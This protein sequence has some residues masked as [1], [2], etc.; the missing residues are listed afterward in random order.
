MY[1]LKIQY[2]VNREAKKYHHYDQVKLIKMN[3]LQAKKYCH[4]LKVE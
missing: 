3:I 4:L 1:N 2:D